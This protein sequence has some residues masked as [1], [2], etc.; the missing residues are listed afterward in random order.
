MPGPPARGRG[1]LE[2]A[3]PFLLRDARLDAAEDPHRVPLL[4]AVQRARRGARLD[5]GEGRDRHQLA[6][7][8]LDLEV[9]QRADRRPVLLADLRDDLVAAVEEVEPVHV[10]PAEQRAQLLADAGQVQP[11]VGDLLAVDHDPRLGQVDLQVGVH[12]EELAAL[13]AGA[14]HR[15]DRLQHLLGRR[16]AL[17]HQLDVVLPGR[18]QRRIEPGEHAESGDLRHRAEHLAVHLLG[19][20]VARL[21]VLGDHAPEAAPVR[22]QRPHELRLGERRDRPHDLLATRG[23]SPRARRRAALRG[24]G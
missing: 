24:T 16:L 7:R 18:R 6:A 3:Q 11:Q 4:E 21:P 19:R 17:E 12:V 15:A 14:D 20:A 13:P 10:G 2:H 8:G 9:E 1:G 22:G 5:P 23:C